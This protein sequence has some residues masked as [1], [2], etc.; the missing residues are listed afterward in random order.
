MGGCGVDE[1]AIDGKVRYLERYCH[2]DFIRQ[3]LGLLLKV[4][5]RLD[6]ECGQ[7]RGIQTGLCVS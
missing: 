4:L 5:V 3:V 2:E 7:D 1:V 6:E